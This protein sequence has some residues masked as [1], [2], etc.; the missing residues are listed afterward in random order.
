MKIFYYTQ[1][2]V[3][4]V[5][6]FFFING[7]SN[8][9]IEKPAAEAPN[10]TTPYT[11]VVKHTGCGTVKPETFKAWLDKDSET[12]Q[13]ITEAFTYSQDSWIA[14]N[15]NLS[16][17]NH[18]LFVR[19]DVTTG[20]WCYAGKSSDERTFFVAPCTDFDKAW[21]EDFELIPDTLTIVYDTTIVKI[22]Q[23]ETK[24]IN[25]PED[26]PLLV[27]GM[28]PATV[29][30]GI[31]N[32]TSKNLK[33]GVFLQHG[34]TILYHKDLAFCGEILVHEQQ[35]VNFSPSANPLTIT[36]Q[37]GDILVSPSDDTRPVFFNGKLQLRVYS[38]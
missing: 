16:M 36:I 17:G 29:K 30:Y 3:I 7:C 12:E 10:I 22:A 1:L 20:S 4:L 23:G 25:L 27:D 28:L 5:V 19:A 26:S 31:R 14:S 9:E 13:E 35:R 24:V 33:F 37:A 6:G 2:I 21:G 34:E 18:T 11:L 8:I 38:L 32:K 15:Y